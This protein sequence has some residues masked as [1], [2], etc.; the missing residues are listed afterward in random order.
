[1]TFDLLEPGAEGLDTLQKGMICE[2]HIFQPTSERV[3]ECLDTD[4]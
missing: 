1:M 4:Y 2:L 3:F